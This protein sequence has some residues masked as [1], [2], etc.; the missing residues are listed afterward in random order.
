MTSTLGEYVTRFRRYMAVLTPDGNSSTDSL[1]SLGRSA[2]ISGLPDD[3]KRNLY[4]QLDLNTAP[5]DMVINVAEYF[6][7]LNSF[8]APAPAPGL[9]PSGHWPST[10]ASS[11]SAT[12]IA[13]ASPRDPMAMEIDNL[14]LELNAVRQQLQRQNQS[15]SSNHPPRL[16]DEE[17][18]RLRATG[19]CF[20]CRRLGHQA[21]QCRKYPV[22]V[23]N[24]DV[25]TSLASSSGSG[26][27]SSGQV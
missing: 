26:N 14:R 10:S 20:R 3:L 24:V 17:R 21:R 13:A 16:S 8:R 25:G 12:P 11:S 15:G 23:N 1:N 19:G 27:A 6:D 5:I 2:F 7:S 22:S 9:G 18:E 4:A